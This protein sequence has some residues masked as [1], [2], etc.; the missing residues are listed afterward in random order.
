M[1]QAGRPREFNEED[2]LDLGI[3]YFQLHGYE[4][5]GLSGL[6][7]R[8]V[9]MQQ[10]LNNSFGDKQS[11]FRQCLIRYRLVQGGMLFGIL[12]KKG[13]GFAELEQVLYTIVDYL[14]K[15][16]DKNC[17]LMKATMELGET[18]S[19][20]LDQVRLHTAYIEQ[21]LYN[22]LL[23]ERRIKK[24]AQIGEKANLLLSSLLGL[25]FMARS[26]LGHDR[27]VS[28]ARSLIELMKR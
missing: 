13:S 22:V 1:A 28:V 7:H 9:S 3:E 11:F 10:S 20:V 26:H 27:M 25:H 18:E 16:P 14:V 6:L 19:V 2:I 24:G 23:N 12:H 5:G 8:L 17:L 21:G 15:E 4:A